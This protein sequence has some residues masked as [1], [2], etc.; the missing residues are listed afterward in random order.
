[1]GWRAFSRSTSDWPDREETGMSVFTDE[2]A[3]PAERTAKPKLATVGA[4]GMPHVVPTSFRY[5][6]AHDT[7]DIDGHDFNRRKKYRD[8]LRHPTSRSWSTTLPR[9]AVAECGIEVRGEV[10]VL[11]TGGTELGPGFAPEMFGSRPGARRQLGPRRR[12]LQPAPGP[13]SEPA[14]RGPGRKHTVKPS[15]RRPGGIGLTTA[16]PVIAPP[17]PPPHDGTRPGA[18]AAPARSAGTSVAQ[19]S[20]A[21]GQRGWKTQPVRRAGRVGRLAGQ[22]DAGRAGGGV[23]LGHRRPQRPECRG[24]A[25]ALSS[26]LVGAA[27][28]DPAE[29]QH[30]RLLAQL[31]HD[32]EVV[33]DEQVGQVPAQRAGGRSAPGSGPAP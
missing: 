29:I 31:A 19:R 32:A 30:R 16:R 15:P 17:A 12:K 25:G 23:D 13:S 21:S 5:N 27:L 18:R 3:L 10:Q 26:S 11:E 2:A 24:G 8:A 14:G 22:H 1:M 20:T 6:P 7:V 4:D 28:H 9:S 33:G